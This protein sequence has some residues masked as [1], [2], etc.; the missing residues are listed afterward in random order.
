MKTYEVYVRAT[1]D[2]SVIVTLEDD[3][4][5]TEDLL[6]SCVKDDIYRPGHVDDYA[7]PDQEPVLTYDSHTHLGDD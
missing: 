3:E 6:M 7:E 5:P 2:C 4:E 1:V